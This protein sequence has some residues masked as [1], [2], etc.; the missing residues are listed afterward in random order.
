MRVLPCVRKSIKVFKKG[1]LSLD[2]C[3]GLDQVWT[4]SGLSLDLVDFVATV[5]GHGQRGAL[6]AKARRLAGSVCFVY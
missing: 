3:Q 4:K 2:F 6:K 1:M 5:A